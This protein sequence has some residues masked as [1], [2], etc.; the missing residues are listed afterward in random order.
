[1]TGAHLV[2]TAYEYATTANELT[3][4]ILTLLQLA[5]NVLE[6]PEPAT[7]DLLGIEVASQ[8][9]PYQPRIACA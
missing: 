8:C 6:R 3:A 2:Q 5:L 9:L 4:P 1:M 7:K